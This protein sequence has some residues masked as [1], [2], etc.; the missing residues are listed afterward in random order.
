MYPESTY[1]Q[2]HSL[3]YSTVRTKC[4][5]S[6]TQ[7][8]IEQQQQQLSLVFDHTSNERIKKSSTCTLIMDMS[9]MY[10]CMENHLTVNGIMTYTIS[11]TVIERLKGS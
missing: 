8:D 4:G 5:Q 10:V 11:V 6:H 1:Y 7:V 2:Y 3:Q 9:R